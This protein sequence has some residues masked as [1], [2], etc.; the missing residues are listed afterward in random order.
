[1][2]NKK[3]LGK[4]P[5]K[6][7]NKPKKSKGNPGMGDKTA[8]SNGEDAGIDIE[9]LEDFQEE[10]DE[11]EMTPEKIVDMYKKKLSGTIGEFV[12]KC[13][14]AKT[15][16]AGIT[17]FSKL[18]RDRKK[19]SNIFMSTV[20]NSMRSNIAKMEREWRKTF[21]RPNRRNGVVKPGQ[22]LKKGRVEVKEGVT[23]TLKFF[24]DRSGSMGDGGLRRA[25]TAVWSVC[26]K[27]KAQYKSNKM[28]KGFDCMVY[29]FDE[30]IHQPLKYGEMYKSGNGNVG[31]DVTLR[32]MVKVST[33]SGENTMLNVIVTDG[34]WSI[35]VNSSLTELRK[36]AGTVI[37][38]TNNEEQKQLDAL[39]EIESKFN[40]FKL[41]LADNDWTLKI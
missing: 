31:F 6:G 11:D 12:A 35:P 28:I 10:L 39:E 7:G 8:W 1:M 2:P 37:F 21:S 24:V 20:V 30:G 4:D 16:G 32:N 26:D 36:M 9:N 14:K 41:I 13:K 18:G 3:D 23:I 25:L 29:P 27:I 33:E 22:M 5:A 38:I 17:G 34:Q 15:E 19:W 40:R